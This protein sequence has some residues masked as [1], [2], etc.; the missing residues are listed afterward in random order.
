M[1][2][3]SVIIDYYFKA[4]EYWPLEKHI[5]HSLLCGS[6][7]IQFHFQPSCKIKIYH[8]GGDC[9]Y[10][11]MHFCKELLSASLSNI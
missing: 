11:L 10:F 3:V 6:E 1:F 2:T 7:S 5:L 8:A 9:A 4:E